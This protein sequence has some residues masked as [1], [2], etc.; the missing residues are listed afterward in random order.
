MTQGEVSQ[1][2]NADVSDDIV[3]LP[4]IQRKEKRRRSME[5]L[6]PMTIGVNNDL[7]ID[8]GSWQESV[9]EDQMPHRLVWPPHTSMYR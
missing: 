1:Q 4:E 2:G 6:H 9:E 5:Q 3:N 8:A 7:T